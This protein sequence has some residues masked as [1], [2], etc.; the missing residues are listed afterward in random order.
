MQMPRARMP[1]RCQANLGNR[2]LWQTNHWNS[3]VR[4]PRQRAADLAGFRSG[5]PLHQYPIPHYL[6]LP[7]CPSSQSDLPIT[8]RPVVDGRTAEFVPLA[9][10]DVRHREFTAAFAASMK[11]KGC[12]L[13]GRRSLKFQRNWTTICQAKSLLRWWK[14]TLVFMSTYSA[15]SLLDHLTC[16]KC[17]R[18]KVVP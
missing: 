11:A 7:Q 2:E 5:Q 16:E 1:T 18:V 9:V 13:S 10:T 4:P 6:H 8:F 3:T 14:F 12:N 17:R 15:K